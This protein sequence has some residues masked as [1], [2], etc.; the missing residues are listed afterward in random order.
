MDLRDAIIALHLGQVV[1]RDVPKR[2]AGVSRQHAEAKTKQLAPGLEDS[3]CSL[4]L[5]RA[6]SRLAGVS[7]KDQL[8]TQSELKLALQQ[9]YFAAGA[10]GVR[11]ESGWRARASW[12]TIG[13]GPI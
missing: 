8:Y 6:A 9:V 10:G 12:T 7:G 3:T 4:A 1:P 11:L 2:F 13:T 5:T